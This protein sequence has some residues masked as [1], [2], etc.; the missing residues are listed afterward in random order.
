MRNVLAALAAVL[1]M[2]LAA[3]ASP[4]MAQPSTVA[5]GSSPY[6]VTPKLGV[7]MPQSDDM[8]VVGFNNGLATEIQVGR[9]FNE[10]FAAELGVGWLSSSTDETFGSKLSLSVVPVTAT[11]K[12]IL[13]FGKTELYGLGGVGAYFSKVELETSEGDL[14]DNDSSLGV[15][16]GVGAQYAITSQLSLGIESRYLVAEVSEA[17]M[18]GFILNGGMAFRF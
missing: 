16:L 12:G 13:P 14:S 1:A 8:D 11:A 10:N 5:P 18:N 15:H 6:Y 3:Y 9:R 4:S 2:P 7:Y 17:D